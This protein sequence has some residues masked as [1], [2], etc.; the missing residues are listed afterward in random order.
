MRLQTYT[1]ITPDCV[2]IVFD[3]TIRRELQIS[4]VKLRKSWFDILMTVLKEGEGPRPVKYKQLNSSHLCWLYRIR[5]TRHLC[6]RL[7]LWITRSLNI[8]IYSWQ[9]TVPNTLLKPIVL[10]RLLGT[11]WGPLRSC[12]PYV[13][14]L[15]SRECCYLGLQPVAL[16]TSRTIRFP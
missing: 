3:T 11:T 4:L 8:I 14:T 2:K 13:G 15:G 16:V 6:P 7:I 10:A 1:N 5:Y 9:T 12:S